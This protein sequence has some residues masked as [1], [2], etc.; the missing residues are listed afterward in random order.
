D[1]ERRGGANSNL[2]S[3]ILEKATKDLHTEGRL[4]RN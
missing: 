4:E 3:L 2:P 1:L